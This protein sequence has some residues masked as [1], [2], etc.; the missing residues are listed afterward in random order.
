MSKDYL[1]YLRKGGVDKRTPSQ[2]TADRAIRMRV[3]TA[4]GFKNAELLS[5]GPEY[6][7]KDPQ[8]LLKQKFAN[9]SQQAVR[10][11]AREAGD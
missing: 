5:E 4:Y 3:K 11:Q 1:R 6:F 9:N 2:K 10:P 7:D 8:K